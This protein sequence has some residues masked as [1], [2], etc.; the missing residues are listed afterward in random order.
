[1][2]KWLSTAPTVGE[3]GEDV[4][5]GKPAVIRSPELGESSTFPAILEIRVDKTQHGPLEVGK[6]V[7]EKFFEGY[8]PFDFNVNFSC[9]RPSLLGGK[10]DYADPRSHWNNVFFGRYQ[11]DTPV[12]APGE[13]DKWERPFGFVR[14]GSNEVNFDDIQRI[15]KADWGYFSNWMYGVPEKDLDAVFAGLKAEPPPRCT[16]LNP[17]VMIN[18]QEYV[19]CE[20]DGV[21]LPSAYVSA[22]DGK[23]LRN[24][25]ALFSPIW[26]RVFGKQGDSVNEDPALAGKKSFHATD[27][28][29]RFYMRQEKRTDPDH[30]GPVYSTVIYGGAV[31]KTWAGDS[32]ERQAVNERFLEA[33]M[34]AVRETMPGPS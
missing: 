5:L 2:R 28:K 30:E 20:I 4:G 10:S 23:G 25:D 7:H 27:M 19:E 24:N 18:G 21:K 14:P 16:V 15:G 6:K 29:V 12:G 34:R 9:A 8:P 31:N 32:P 22:E 17:S 26:R 13:K 1:M 3:I 11:I 33:Q